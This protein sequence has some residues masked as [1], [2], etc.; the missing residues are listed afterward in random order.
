MSEKKGALETDLSHSN[1]CQLE[2]QIEEIE[3]P[4]VEEGG[5]PA[6]S[7]LGSQVKRVSGKERSAVLKLRIKF[8]LQ[9]YN[10]IIQSSCFLYSS[11][12]IMKTTPSKTKRAIVLWK[13]TSAKNY[14]FKGKTQN[15]QKPVSF[16]AGSGVNELKPFPAFFIFFVTIYSLVQYAQL[17]TGTLVLA[18]VGMNLINCPTRLYP[19][20]EEVALQMIIRLT[21]PK[22]GINRWWAFRIKDCL[23]HPFF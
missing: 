16:Y 2:K 5:K 9:K 15:G 14:S 10:S 18:R 11:L 19:Q 20:G 22:G 8:L 7:C 17:R 23:E 6:V 21:I 13:T 12:K 3:K 1:I 4:W